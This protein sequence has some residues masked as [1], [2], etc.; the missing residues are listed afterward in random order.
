MVA[1]SARAL[2]TVPPPTISATFIANVASS[3]ILFMVPPRLLLVRVSDAQ[4]LEAKRLLGS[5]ANRGEV[6]LRTS[7]V[8][9]RGHSAKVRFGTEPRTKWDATVNRVP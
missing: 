4:I 8:F 2:S 6:R 9:S 3:F 1:A 7:N 5:S